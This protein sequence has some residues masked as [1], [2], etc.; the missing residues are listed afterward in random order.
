MRHQ[1]E[2]PLHGVTDASF[3]NSAGENVTGPILVV[4]VRLEQPRVVPL[5]DHNEGD[6]RAVS[7]LKR[8]TGLLDRTNLFQEQNHVG[9]KGGNPGPNT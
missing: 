1:I 3:D 8:R 7:A 6:A 2:V 9:H 4:P 5:L